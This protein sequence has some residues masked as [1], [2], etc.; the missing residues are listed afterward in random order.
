MA[1]RVLPP[2]LGALTRFSPDV[3]HLHKQPVFPEP[4]DQAEV[5][6]VNRV[7]KGKLKQ[8]GGSSRV[9]LGKLGFQDFR[10]LTEELGLSFEGGGLD[11]GPRDTEGLLEGQGQGVGD[12]EEYKKGDLCEIWF[13]VLVLSLTSIL[14]F[15]KG[16]SKA[17]HYTFL[18][19]PFNYIFL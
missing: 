15:I 9:L 14:C 5:L 17:S 12:K 18:Y 3:Q 6:S 19:L 11:Q 13:L 16:F 7:K 8:A 1:Q 2:F 4:G 10:K